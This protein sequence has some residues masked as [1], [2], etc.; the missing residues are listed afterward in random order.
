MRKLF[1]ELR[2]YHV[3]VCRTCKSQADWNSDYEQFFCP[4]DGA[5]LSDDQVKW[6]EVIPLRK[7]DE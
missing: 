6:I 5:A 3:P 4:S 1:S 2:I 7:E